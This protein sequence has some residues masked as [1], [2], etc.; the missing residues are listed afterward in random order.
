MRNEGSG[1]AARAP[2]W[3]AEREVTRDEARALIGAQF[4]ELAG[5]SVEPFGNG[6]DNTAYLVGDIYVF[7]FPRRTIAVE[8]IEREIAILPIIAPLLP[9]PIPVPR[10]TG[11]P[12]ETFPWPF[13]GYAHLAGTTA[14]ALPDAAGGEA[15][16]RELGVFLR[17][18][19]AI[20]P[21]AAVERGLPP[22]QLGR[23]VHERRLAMARDR[24]D[25]LRGAG[26]IDDPQP[27]LDEMSAIA[28]QPGEGALRLV[29]GDFYARHVLVDDRGELSGVID[30][31]DMHLG[32]PALD[33]AIADLV[34]TAEHQPAFFAA[35]GPVDA[36]TRARAR[37]RAIYHAALVADYGAKASDP[38]LQRAGTAA[39]MR[40]CAGLR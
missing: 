12:A 11:T 37:Y 31:G 8:L 32:D 15:L 25:A 2:Q 39:L 21:S 33:L 38:A 40:I 26:I 13:A 9:T 4:P 36:R 35:Y 17:A 22:D 16:A 20:D 19:H 24:L 3:T 7:R 23:L 30:W 28:P 14:C 10:F 18:L 34:L 27:L 29:H 5:A 1:R 6:W